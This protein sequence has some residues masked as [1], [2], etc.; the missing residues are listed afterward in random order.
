MLQR[1]VP[2]QGNAWDV[3][4][5]E[6]RR[7]FDRVTALPPLD[8]DA[9]TSRKW[10]RGNDAVPLLVAEAIG[11]FLSTAE[12]LGRRTGELHV[13]LA[14][15]P[16]DPRFVAEPY[17]EADLAETSRRMREHAMQQFRLLEASLPHLDERRRQMAADTLARRNDLIQQFEAL[18]T[19]RSAGKRIRCHGDYHL[20]QVLVAEGDVVILDFEGEPARGIADRR[21]KSS[22]LRDVAGMLR[23]FSY[24]TLTAL[25]AATHTRPEDVE[26]LAP[27][28]SLWELWISAAFLR[29]YLGASD[30]ASLLPRHA[31]DADALLGAFMMDKTLYELGYELNNRPDWVH[32]P[33]AA[34]LNIGTRR[35]R[36]GLRLAARDS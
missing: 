7:Y 35:Y 12:V 26:R 11:P 3:T 30:E 18:T 21:L 22:P 32:I 14:S 15:A 17:S 28:A 24:A 34:L 16:E 36:Q 27:W 10:L 5:E 25:A 2:N 31:D 8:P 23:S 20:G 33:L 9:E 6:V 4:V 13:A 1:Y 29:A 19:L